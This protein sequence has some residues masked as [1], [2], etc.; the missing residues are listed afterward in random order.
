MYTVIVCVQ[1]EFWIEMYYMYIMYIS[2]YYN[3][4]F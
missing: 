2:K 1:N 4:N 3:H